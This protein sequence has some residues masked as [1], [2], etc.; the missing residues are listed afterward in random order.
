MNQS[1]STGNDLINS[2]P[3]RGRRKG[4][5]IALRITLLTWMVAMVTL[6]IFIFVTTPQEKRM[7]LQQLES[8]ANS[9]S[10]SLHDAAAGAAVNEDYASVIS[11]AQTMLDGDPSLDFL[12]VVKNDGFSLVIEQSGW[13]VLNEV[14]KYWI[15]RERKSTGEI[16]TVPLFERRVFHYAKPFDYSGIQWGW[17]HVGLALDDYDQNIENLH[18]NTMVLALGCIVFSLVVSL[19]NARHV[20]GP[21][22]RLRHIVQK[23]AE[24]DLAARAAEGR[25]DEIGSLA[26]SVNIMAEALLRKDRVLESVRFA[27]QQFMISS[28]WEEVTDAVLANMGKS[29]DVSRAYIFENHTGNSGSLLASQRFEWAAEGISPEIDNPD[30]QNM[31]YDKIGM[32][33]WKEILMKDEIICG[34]VHKFSAGIREI[35]EPQGIRSILVIPIYAKDE[36]WGFL[37][38]DD[39]VNEREWSNAEID[40]LSAG[41]DMLGAT[42]V[43]QRFQE[44][45]MEAKETLEQRVMERTSEL[46]TQIAAKEEALTELAEAQ[47]S[48]VEASRTAG[49]AEVATGVLHNVGN[50]LNSVNVSC[51]LILDQLRESRVV[52]LARVTDMLEENQDDLLRF[53]TEDPRGR[54]IPEYLIALSSALSEEHQVMQQESEDLQGRIEHIKEIVTMQQSYG[55]VSG[56]SE[57]LSVQHLMEDAVKINAGAL[58]RHNILIRRQY[59]SVPPVTV[60]KHMVLQILLNLISNAKYACT[61]VE[62]EEKIITLKVLKCNRDRIQI[63]VEDNGIGITRENLNRIFQHG[64]TTKRSGHGF[65]L[66]SGALTARKLGGSLSVHSDGVGCGAVFTLELPCD[67]EKI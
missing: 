23:I 2:T 24:G 41:A 7:F 5:G 52:K 47:S 28:K 16:L 40:S 13:K 35:L 15:D 62:K 18:F 30:L 20:V 37:G 1:A 65:G 36:W 59:E 17:I 42:I 14:D 29:A 8:R 10:L 32:S 26:G 51:T 49:M 34:P 56:V 33:N 64:F 11:A 38:F 19:V 6:L 27:S 43:R 3:E 58:A 21:I 44:A 12:L 67:Q 60:D 25:N 50:V 55:R 45:L 57:T 4:L 54:K 48:L 31:D 61:D 39:C 63:K 46:Q 9:V 22:L 53:F 66:H